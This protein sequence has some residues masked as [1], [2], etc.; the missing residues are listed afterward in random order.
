MVRNVKEN[1]L[2]QYSY[3]LRAH[4]LAQFHDIGSSINETIH[5][6][7]CNSNVGALANQIFAIC[8]SY[9]ETWICEK[10]C[11]D[12]TVSYASYSLSI[13]DIFMDFENIITKC[14]QNSSKNTICQNQCD[15]LRRV[16]KIV[17]RYF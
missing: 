1:G 3:Q 7:N 12:N 14:H 11:L 10:G 8:P 6:I 5:H 9:E 13:D 2:G 16:N 15:G 4:V 17:G